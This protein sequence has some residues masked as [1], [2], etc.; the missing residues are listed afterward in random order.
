LHIGVEQVVNQQ[1]GLQMNAIAAIGL[2][3]DGAWRQPVSHHDADIEAEIGADVDEDVR[4]ERRR[5]A[6]EVR[7]SACS[8]I[9]A[10]ISSPPTLAERTRKSAPK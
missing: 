5:A 6:R 3:Q 7:Q 1:I 10:E 9:L 2:E 4:L 8:A